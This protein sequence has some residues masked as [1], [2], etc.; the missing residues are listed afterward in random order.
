MRSMYPPEGGR[1]LLIAIVLIPVVI[2]VL[3]VLVVLVVVLVV[4]VV[5]VVVLVVVLIVLLIVLFLIVVSIVL[6]FCCTPFYLNLDYNSSMRYPLAFYSSRTRN[7]A[8][9]ADP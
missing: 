3:V 7:T 8:I 2:L 9:P 6:H 4:L 5:L 1:D